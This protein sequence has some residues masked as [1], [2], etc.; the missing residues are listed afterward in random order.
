MCRAL[1]VEICCNLYRI[2]IQ[3][4]KFNLKEIFV[5]ILVLKLNRTNLKEKLFIPKF[6]SVK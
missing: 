4:G 1:T 2:S 5:L 6:G 3:I